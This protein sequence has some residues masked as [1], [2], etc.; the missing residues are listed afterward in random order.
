MIGSRHENRRRFAPA[1]LKIPP[2]LNHRCNKVADSGRGITIPAVGSFDTST[3]SSPPTPSPVGSRPSTGLRPTSSSANDDNRTGTIQAKPASASAGTIHFD[4]VVLF[5][6]FVSGSK[7]LS[8]GPARLAEILPGTAIHI[9]LRIQGLRTR[10]FRRVELEH[11][12]L[13]VR[14]ARVRGL[15]Q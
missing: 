10:V 8:A 3:T 14:N 12:P 6:T 9:A 2:P 13:R 5:R 11:H 4:V 7:A 1:S 15:V